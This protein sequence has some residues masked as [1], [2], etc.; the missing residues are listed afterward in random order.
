MAVTHTTNRRPQRLSRFPLARRFRQG[1]AEK[2]GARATLSY[3]AVLAVLTGL[4]Q[5]LGGRG[6]GHPAK[7]GPI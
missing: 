5:G 3:F 6:E 2:A 7:L 4:V 1:G